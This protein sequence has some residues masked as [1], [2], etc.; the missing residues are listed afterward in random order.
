MPLQGAGVTGVCL[1]SVAPRPREVSLLLPYTSAAECRAATSIIYVG[2]AHAPHCVWGNRNRISPRC[3]L[4]AGKTARSVWETHHK[5]H[6][7]TGHLPN[8]LAGFGFADARGAASLGKL[9]LSSPSR[10]LLGAP[11]RQP[12][13]SVCPCLCFLRLTRITEPGAGQGRRTCCRGS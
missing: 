8:A 2:Y 13:L 1:P 4:P 9:R 11:F 6:K 12:K 10:H 7:R 5:R 3:C